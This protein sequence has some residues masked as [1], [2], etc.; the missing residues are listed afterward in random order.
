[1]RRAAAAAALALAACSPGPPPPVASPSP[2]A[3]T[4]P[5]SA[6]PSPATPRAIFS[7]ERVL[8]DA[9]YLAEE[10][11]PREATS[12]PYL[13]AAAFVRRRLERL[14]YRVF[15]QSVDLPGGRSSTGVDLGDGTTRNVVGEPHGVRLSRPHLVVGA[16]LDTVPFSPGANDNGSGV[17]AM[18]ELARLA[19]LRAPRT[20]MVFVAFGGEE[21]RHPGELGHEY[22]SRAY[23][24]ELGARAR[25]GLR[26][27]VSLDMVG[28][29]DRVFVC[30]G[31]RAP[32]GLLRAFRSTARRLGVPTDSCSVSERRLSD[33]WPFE[34]AGFD[35][36][37][38]WAGDHPTLHTSR[39][40]AHVVRKPQIRRVG[41][42]A[43]ETLKDYRP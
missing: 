13:R 31:G 26:G 34:R 36:A 16:H 14:G 37:W 41:R 18:L 15:E 38:L 19:T 29:G 9:R 21:R 20:P 2:P 39:D 8:E 1:M 28:N 3:T 4:A 5:P 10:I 30:T 27:M 22:G 35:A 25:R 32:G 17:A 12:G 6:T 43:W 11:G 23:V 40:T 42:V 24:E 7:V 33:H